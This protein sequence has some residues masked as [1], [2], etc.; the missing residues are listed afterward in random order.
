M[1][2][3]SRGKFCDE[4]TYIDIVLVEYTRYKK[5]MLHKIFCEKHN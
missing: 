3:M 4:K 1:Y 5:L 2:E